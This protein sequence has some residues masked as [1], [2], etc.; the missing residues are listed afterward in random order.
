MAIE[1][2]AAKF[3]EAG[4]LVFSFANVFFDCYGRAVSP[5]EA[6]GHQMHTGLE[7]YQY[8]TQELSQP[9]YQEK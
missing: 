3:R 5:R 1:T 7:Y 4:A 8:I 9:R 6:Q 2:G